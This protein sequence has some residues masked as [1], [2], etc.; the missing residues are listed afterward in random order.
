MLDRAAPRA[1]WAA[2]RLAV[3]LRAAH[4]RPQDG[5]LA[6]GAAGRW[7]PAH[8]SGVAVRVGW[9]CSA[10]VLARS[11]NGLRNWHDFGYMAGRRIAVPS[12]FRIEVNMVVLA[13]ALA[14]DTLRLLVA[15]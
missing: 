11:S 7:R 10:S 9:R 5:V 13:R 15:G 3:G 2:V 6:V 4:L 1:E 8:L 12:I 14:G